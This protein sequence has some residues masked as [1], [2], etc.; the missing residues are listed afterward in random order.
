MR[1]AVAGHAGADGRT[2]E[3]RNR[4]GVHRLASGGR[5]RRRPAARDDVDELHLAAEGAGELEHVPLHAAEVLIRVAA[6][7]EDPQAATTA[8]HAGP[9]ARTWASILMCDRT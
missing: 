5:V 2:A 6:E 7:D 1:D 4:A 9:S 8:G 3:V